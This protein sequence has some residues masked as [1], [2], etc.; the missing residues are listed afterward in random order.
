[1][2]LPVYVYGMSVLRKIAREVPEDY[3]GNVPVDIFDPDALKKEPVK[4]GEPTLPVDN[5]SIPSFEMEKEER[6][7]IIDRLKGL[8]Y[9]D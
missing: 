4:R 6:D 7:E 5:L 9:L 8:G 1:M 2:V 3:E